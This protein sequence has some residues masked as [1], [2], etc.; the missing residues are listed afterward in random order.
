M[1]SPFYVNHPAMASAGTE[2]IGNVALTHQILTA[3]TA[4]LLKIK[5]FLL[6]NVCNVK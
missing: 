4:K 6:K 5:T 1:S 2:S 3:K